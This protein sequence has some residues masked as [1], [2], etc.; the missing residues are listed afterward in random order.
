MK[1]YVIPVESI[2]GLTLGKHYKISEYSVNHGQVLIS[3]EKGKSFSFGLYDC[4][5]RVVSEDELARQNLLKELII[6]YK[7][8][9]DECYDPDCAYLI[10]EQIID[11][12]ENIVN[13]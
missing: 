13:K 2:E 7:Q 4:R 5:I 11:D 3:N 9:S 1:Y 12:L 8:K 10:Y 6:E